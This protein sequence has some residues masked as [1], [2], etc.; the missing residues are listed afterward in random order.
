MNRFLLI[1]M[2]IVPLFSQSKRDPRVVGLA[3]SYTTI[4]EGIFSVGYN[5]GLIGLQHDRP[6]TI[7]G[8]QID[9][10]LLGNFF[11]IENIAKYSGDT[12][13][14]RDV[15]KFFK[16]LRNQNGLSFFMDTHMPIP[17]INISKGNLAF[18][19]NNILLQN[20][21]LP[22]GLLELIFYGNGKKANLDLEFSYEI[23][24][25]N[26]YGISF[27][28]P[29]K[30]MSWGITAKYMQGL[31]YLGVDDDSSS[32]S[33]ITDDLGIYGNGKYIIKQGVG[34]SGFGLDIGVV[35]RPL[36]GW[37][38]GLSVINLM[39]S[40]RWEQGGEESTSS[41]NPLT[42]S[43][44]PFKWGDDELSSDEYIEYT[45]TIDTIRADKMSNDSLFKNETKFLKIPSNAKDFVTRMPATFRAGASKQF[46]NFLIA[47]DL[48]AGFE[49]RYYARKQWKWSI[50]TE[51]S[52]MPTLPLRIGF[53]WGGGDFKE[54]G[55]GFGLKKSRVMFDFGFAFRNGM[56]LHTMKG[57]NLSLGI[58]YIGKTDKKELSNDD[59]PSPSNQ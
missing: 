40:I 47:S 13:S 6:L 28:I 37:S 39:G 9:F 33:L 36:D 12:L 26:E 56:W 46:N 23:L 21:K 55:I 24:G 48:V 59:G 49:N 31:F 20:Y 35:S 18:S 45:F 43:F 32:S 17:L 50:G 11:S 14:T 52:R 7:Q 27:G 2:M 34:G 44:Y 10:G 22:M 25:V 53:G 38:F 57:L 16:T 51:W 8:F 19:A 42:K 5:P 54:L 30:Y 29:F 58:T 4:A 15:N 41:I 3:G 1:L